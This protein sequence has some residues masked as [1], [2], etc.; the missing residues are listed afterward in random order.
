VKEAQKKGVE[1]LHPMIGEA[2]YFK[3]N[4]QST[5]WWENVK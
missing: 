2:I 4:I 5:A 1:V 3:E